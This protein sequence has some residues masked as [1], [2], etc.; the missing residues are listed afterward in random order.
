MQI[1]AST[2]LVAAPGLPPRCAA[3]RR[4]SLHVARLQG[5]QPDGLAP[6]LETTGL[7]VT[8]LTRQAFGVRAGLPVAPRVSAT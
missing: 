6:P 3:S 7:S 8:A 4:L 2:T 5:R 1:A